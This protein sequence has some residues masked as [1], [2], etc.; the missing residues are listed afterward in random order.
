[1]SSF[2][3]GHWIVIGLIGY[4]LWRV[5][6]GGKTS[7]DSMYCTT[8]GHEGPT[9]LQTKGSM[10]I[11]IVLWLC[12]LVPGIIYSLWRISSRQKACTSCGATTLVPINSPVAVAKKK[13]LNS[14]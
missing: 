5:L 12:F 14:Y 3:L 13:Q 11:E 1:M 8:C 6:G 9:T 7:G 10:G 2:S 4:L